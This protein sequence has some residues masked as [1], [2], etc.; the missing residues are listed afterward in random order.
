L[1]FVM[2][3]V[4]AI[5]ESPE[6]FEARTGPEQ[7]AYWAAW[8]AYAAALKHAGVT[9]GGK[10]LEPP[11]TATTVRLRGGERTVQ[12]GPY[13]DT[14]EQLG[15]FFVIDVPDLDTAMEWAARCPASWGGAAVEIRPALGS[16]QAPANGAAHAQSQPALATV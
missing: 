14:K 12:D 4:M 1:E 2:Q 5:Y 15:G 9:T 3:Y 6:A 16:C 13:A 11:A 7:G 8:Q 10:G